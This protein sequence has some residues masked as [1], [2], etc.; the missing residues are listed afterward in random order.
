MCR[1]IYLVICQEY[2]LYY[3]FSGHLPSEVLPLTV[4]HIGQKYGNIFTLRLFGGRIVV[5]NGYKLVKEALVQRGDD[6]T[7]RPSI[8]VFHEMV[9]TKGS[10]FSNGN[11]WKQQRRFALHTLRNFGVG[12]KTLELFIQEECRY[13]T[14]AFADHQG[15][16]DHFFL[17]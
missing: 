17:Q 13:L 10:I 14:E 7:D 9:G 2:L 6:F 8:P 4:T 15:T 11:P 5:L 16:I 1:Y 3:S 12:K